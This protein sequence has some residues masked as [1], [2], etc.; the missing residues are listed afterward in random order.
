MEQRWKLFKISDW[1]IVTTDCFS[2]PSVPHIDT[3]PAKTQ[4]ASFEESKL[5]KGTK[6]AFLTQC[7][8]MSLGASF[9]VNW[10]S[11]PL[12]CCVSKQVCY[13]TN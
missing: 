5:Y 12:W 8:V 10:F 6:H 3:H 13:L 9:I 1:L 7:I 4:A 2:H 11:Y